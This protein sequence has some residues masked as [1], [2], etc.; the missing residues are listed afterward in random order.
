MILENKRYDYHPGDKHKKL[1]G[2]W[3]TRV[4]VAPIDSDINAVVSNTVR[5]VPAIGHGIDQTWNNIGCAHGK[6][7]ATDKFQHQSKKEIN[8]TSV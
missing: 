1:T 5:Q 3:H 2:M 7:K 8:S 4:M 6:P